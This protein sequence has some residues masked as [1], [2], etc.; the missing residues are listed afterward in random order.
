[1]AATKQTDE[2]R[3]AVFLQKHL[4]ALRP[5]ITNAVLNAITAAAGSKVRAVQMK[6]VEMLRP[7][8]K[9]PGFS[10]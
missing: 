1:V 10:A 9:E 8:L 2:L 7:V 4:P 3:R 5:F 6:R